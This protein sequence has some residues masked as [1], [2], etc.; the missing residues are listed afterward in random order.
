MS[1]FLGKLSIAEALGDL[2]GDKVRII[3]ALAG[4]IGDAGAIAVQFKVFGS[5]FSYFYRRK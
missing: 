5:I 4:T 1:I 2:Y 3:V